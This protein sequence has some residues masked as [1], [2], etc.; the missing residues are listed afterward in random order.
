MT[1][2]L[3]KYKDAKG[4]Q[5]VLGL[6]VLDKLVEKKMAMQESSERGVCNYKEL[7]KYAFD[8]FD[9]IIYPSEGLRQ[10]IKQRQ[11]SL[12]LLKKNERSKFENSINR[13]KKANEKIRE[14]DMKFKEAE[15][16]LKEATKLNKAI[17]RTSVKNS[18]F[19]TLHDLRVGTNFDGEPSDRISQSEINKRI[20][21][22]IKVSRETIVENNVDNVYL[23][24]TGKVLSDIRL[25]TMRQACQIVTDV[26]KE[27]SSV[28]EVYYEGIF[29]NEK[30]FT[31]EIVYRNFRNTYV[32]LNER[33]ASSLKFSLKSYSDH[34]AYDMD[35]HENEYEKTIKGK[36]IYIGT[37]ISG[38]V[39]INNDR[40]KSFACM[41]VANNV[42]FVSSGSMF[43]KDS[44][45][46]PTTQV[47][48]L[49]NTK[50]LEVKALR[51]TKNSSIKEL[52]QSKLG[53]NNEAI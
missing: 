38:D 12:G 28:A 32:E 4:R 52:L 9:S 20:S 23:M 30:Q 33:I 42:H 15:K 8:E 24:L 26:I 14:A 51:I 18:M 48:I 29:I 6:S 17:S 41:E 5:Q 7:A 47:A 1:E 37:D 22:F 43:R 44:H 21:D 34:T 13:M 31:N 46:P 45:L 36:I 2:Q 27:L 53:D 50:H 19:L 35:V 16:M 40:Q 3:R 39:N 49:I 11:S 10:L 25:G